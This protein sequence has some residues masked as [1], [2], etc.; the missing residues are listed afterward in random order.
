MLSPYLPVISAIVVA[1]I[2]FAGNYYIG[3]LK[4]KT[5]IK[6]ITANASD[7]LRDDLLQIIDRYEKREQ[8]LVDRIDRNEKQNDELQNTIGLL[9]QEI[10]ALRIEN[11]GL[12][13]ELQITRKELEK[14]ERKVYY[15]PEKESKE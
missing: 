15:I 2:T 9:R 8:F 13:A 14:F 7:A 3:K 11:Q 12:K 4:T 6:T 10:N 5:D 1:I